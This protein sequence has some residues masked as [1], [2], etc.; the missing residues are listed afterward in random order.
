M[1]LS[2][3]LKNKCA[4]C[5][6]RAFLKKNQIGKVQPTIFKWEEDVENNS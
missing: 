4:E 1:K 5:E 2:L 3:F 6:Y